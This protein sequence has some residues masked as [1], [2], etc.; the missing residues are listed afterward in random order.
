ML[1]NDTQTAYASVVLR[2]IGTGLSNRNAFS[3]RVETEGLELKIVREV[4]GG[5]SFQS[6]SDRRIHIGLGDHQTIPVLRVR[7]PDDTVAEWN[8]V[9]P[10]QYIAVEGR[11]Q[12]RRTGNK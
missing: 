7:W 12:M 3:A 1:R 5:G 2:L 8:D 11:E 9:A 4:I 6:A 10:G